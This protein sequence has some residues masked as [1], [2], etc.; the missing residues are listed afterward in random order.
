MHALNLK[1]CA[2]ILYSAGD[3]N[4]IDAEAST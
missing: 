1:S 2:W 3:Q 4:N